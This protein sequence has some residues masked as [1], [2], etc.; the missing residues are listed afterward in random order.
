M[1][2]S[3]QNFPEQTACCVAMNGGLQLEAVRDFTVNSFGIF[4]YY[5]RDGHG[6]VRWLTDSSGSVT[7]TYDYDAF[8]N[9]ISST[10]TTFNNYLFAGEQ[11]D[12][13]LGIYFNR[14]RYYDQRQGRSWTADTVD[15]DTESPLALHRYLYVSANPIN[16]TDPTG[17]EELTTSGQA[18]AGAVDSIADGQQ[19]VY[20]FENRLVQ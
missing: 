13:A 8:G 19:N 4:H 5:G 11:F 18:T 10:G 20:D 1:L 9:L 17:N 3:S 2:R 16:K 15:G 6:S 7:D 14:A 12:P